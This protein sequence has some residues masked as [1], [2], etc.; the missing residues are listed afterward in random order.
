[1]PA[2]VRGWISFDGSIFV[3]GNVGELKSLINRNLLQS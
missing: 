3:S 1:M 2:C